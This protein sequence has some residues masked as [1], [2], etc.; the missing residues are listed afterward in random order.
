VGE[1]NHLVG[2]GN[3]V[4]FAAQPQGGDGYGSMVGRGYRIKF[5]PLSL[6]MSSSSSHFCFAAL[7]V[8]YP[9]VGSKQMW[10]VLV[11]VSGG[12]VMYVV[13]DVSGRCGVEGLIQGKQ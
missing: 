3:E 6:L 7:L 9:V 4:T 8:R 13:A 10:R 12:R 11:V 5:N 1:K 2:S